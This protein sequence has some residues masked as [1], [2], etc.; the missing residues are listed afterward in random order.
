MTTYA[1][2]VDYDTAEEYY[3]L[4]QQLELYEITVEEFQDRVASLKGYPLGRQL[5]PGDDLRVVL[6]VKAQVLVPRSLNRQ[7]KKESRSGNSHTH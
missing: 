3:N 4:S 2:N 1:W 6:D 7:R 5:Q